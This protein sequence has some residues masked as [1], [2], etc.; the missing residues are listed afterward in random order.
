MDFNGCIGGRSGHIHRLRFM[1]DPGVPSC[2]L[3][4]GMVKEEIEFWRGGI[5]RI[6]GTADALAALV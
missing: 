3:I 2:R 6:C 1:K 5:R 4:C